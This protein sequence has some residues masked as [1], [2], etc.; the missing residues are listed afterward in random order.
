[1]QISLPDSKV[2][3]IVQK[4]GNIINRELV[5]IHQVAELVGLFISACPAVQY[6]QLYTRQLEFEKTIAL[7]H[8]GSYNKKFQLSMEANSDISW[9]VAN[10]NGSSRPI[11]NIYYSLVITTDASLTGWGAECNGKTTRGAWSFLERRKHVCDWNDWSHEEQERHINEL[12]VLALFYG[13]KSLADV[14]NKNIL[15]RMDNTTAISYVNKYGGCRASDVHAL[16]KEIW[17]WCEARNV[18]LFASYINT[19]ANVVADSLSREKIDSF[20]FMLGD[21]YFQKICS[22]LGKPDIDLFAS[23]ITR[24]CEKYVSWFPNPECEWVDAFTRPWDKYF[25][26][27]PPFKLLLKVLQKICDEGLTG[28]VVAPNWPTQPWYP[29][30][31]KLVNNNKILFFEPST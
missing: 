30:F 6:G 17:Q 24:R 19:K 3:K 14:R 21:A 15:C 25:Y 20:D 28:I 13:L 12:E 29:L 4:A 8:H 7:Q 10:L 9:W 1:M 22:N 26:A 16:A 5:S 27:F 18:I 31:C 23:Y 11:G 2:R